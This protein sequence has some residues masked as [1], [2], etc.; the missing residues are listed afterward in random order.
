[1]RFLRETN[2]D[3]I[4]YRWWALGLSGLVTLIGIGHVI[5]S[6]GLRESI[7]FAGGSVLQYRFPQAVAAEDIRDVLA[8]REPKPP[9]GTYP[10][11]PPSFTSH[12]R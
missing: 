11:Q 7:D 1:M 6:G 12:V 8:S 5:V 4:G 10:D 3:F 9:G 2:I